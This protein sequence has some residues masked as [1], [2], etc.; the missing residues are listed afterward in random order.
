VEIPKVLP[1]QTPAVRAGTASATEQGSQTPPNVAPPSDHVD[2]RPLDIPA[3][4]QILLAEVRSA[5]DAVLLVALEPAT[6]RGRADAPDPPNVPN[7]GV[8]PT[9]IQ[10]ARV[11]VNMFLQAVPAEAEDAAAWNATL[12]QLETAFQSSVEGALNAVAAW[13]DLP[14]GVLAAAT[15]TR[16]LAFSV[17]AGDT[18]NPLW[19]RPEWADLAPR[20]QRF[21]RRRRRLRRRLQDPD[22]PATRFD[23]SEQ[24]QGPQ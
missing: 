5:L 21:W 13:R 6:D 8:E 24:Q 20:I 17:L 3:A 16:Q 11:L 7:L 2:I 12:A 18:Q 4:L 23:E 19:L 15:E 14:P 1:A 22:Y 9:P 10:T